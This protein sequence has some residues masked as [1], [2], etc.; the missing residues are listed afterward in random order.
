MTWSFLDWQV[1]SSKWD[2]TGMPCFWNAGHWHLCQLPLV[3]LPLHLLLFN[4]DFSRYNQA[5]QAQIAAMIEHKQVGTNIDTRRTRDLTD[6]TY[7]PCR[8]RISLDSTPTLSNAA[9]KTVLKTLPPRASLA[10]RYVYLCDSKKIT[11]GLTSG[12][13]YRKLVSTSVLTSSWS[14]LNV[15]VLALLNLASRY[16]VDDDMGWEYLYGLIDDSSWF[17]VNNRL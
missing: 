4:M 6:N 13:W 8:W 11:C 5:E 17:P 16:V 10:R 12:C 9:L 15:L 14:T 1:N 2:V 3:T 7:P